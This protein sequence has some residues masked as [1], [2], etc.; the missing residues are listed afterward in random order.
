MIRILTRQDVA[1]QAALFEQMHRARASVFHDR[2]RWAVKVEHGWEIDRYDLEHDPVYLLCIDAGGLAIG[3]LRLLPTT[4]ETMLK[5]D[6]ATMF[7]E[8]V[9]FES[10]TAWECTR[11]CVHPAGDRDLAA[12]QHVSTELLIGIC[13]LALQ[14]GIDQIVGLYDQ[15]MVRIYRR[16]GWSPSP[17][18]TTERATERLTVGIWDVSA[19]ALQRMQARLDF[20]ARSTRVA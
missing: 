16:I 3:S 19:Q 10:P 8:D 2:L 7:D 1:A 17:L 20:D 11:F 9:C 14:S 15:R 13:D 18:A 5:G 12:F 4:G 6:F